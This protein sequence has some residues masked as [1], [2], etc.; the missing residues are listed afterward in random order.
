MTINT[1]S[2][3][4]TIVVG[5]IHGC[6]DE[7]VDLLANADFAASDRL[8]AVGDLIT[9]GPK[10]SQVLDRF[11]A[12]EQFSSV[13]GNHDLAVLR[14]W[15]GEQVTLTSWQRKAVEE[16]QRNHN[17]YQRYLSSLPFCIDLS[18]HLIVHAGMRPDVP[19]LKQDHR[20]LTELRT[21]GEH[22]TSREGTAWYE[23]YQ[24]EQLVLFGHWPAPEPRRGRRAI[25]LDTGCVYG[26]R[27]TAFIIETSEIIT[28][29]AHRPYASK[30]P[31]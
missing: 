19:L 3:P 4:R 20:D 26:G 24:G 16:L 27:L 13:I 5:D 18:T 23:A 29:P 6:Y 11:I 25:G 8:I 10:N 15:R 28:V 7:L 2:I 31:N 9:K 22:R 17:S 30:A 1:T 12:D 14:Y 21:L